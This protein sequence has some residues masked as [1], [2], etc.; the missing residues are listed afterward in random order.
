MFSGRTFCLLAVRLGGLKSGI[1]N[2]TFAVCAPDTDI[3][4][5]HY[6]AAASPRASPSTGSARLF[7]NPPRRGPA[8]LAVGGAAVASR[9]SHRSLWIKTPKRGES[10]P[11]VAAREGIS[12]NS[13][14]RNIGKAKQGI[15]SVSWAFPMWNVCAKANSTRS[16]A[17]HACPLNGGWI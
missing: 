16:S 6:P 5:N 2:L 13:R 8:P 9:S 14:G 12:Q 11:S 10:I 1:L 7:R 15:D 3:S 17:R 4:R